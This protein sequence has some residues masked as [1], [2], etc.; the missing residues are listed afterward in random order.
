MTS[1]P[2]PHRR[3]QRMMAL[4]AG[5][6]WILA[7]L[8]AWWAWR[9]PVPADPVLATTRSTRAATAPALASTIDTATWNTLLWQPFLDEAPVVA[10]ATPSAFKLFSI[11]QQG[12]GLTAAIAAGDQAGLL[13]VKAGDTGNGFTVVRV[14]A[15]GVVLRVNGQEQRLGLNP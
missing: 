10:S 1:A 15:N 12:D 8:A 4:Q 13:Y 3:F 9:V 14:E 11:L 7:L 6:C 5:A 2:D